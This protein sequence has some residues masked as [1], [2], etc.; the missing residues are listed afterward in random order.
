MQRELH[1]II[2][3]LLAPLAFTMLHA[4]IE[5]EPNNSDAT[6][7]AI[8]LSSPMQGAMGAACSGIADDSDDHFVLNLPFDATLRIT[9][10]S[11]NPTAATHNIDIDVRQD[12][13]LLFTSDRVSGNNGNDSTVT[14]TH[15]CLAKGQY[16]LRLSMAFPTCYQY[17]LLVT[18]VPSLFADDEEPNDDFSAADSQPVLNENVGTEGHVGFTY[19]DDNDDRYRIQ[20]ANDGT[21]SVTLEASRDG[22]IVGHSLLVD[23]YKNGDPIWNMQALAGVNNT[24]QISIGS[25]DCLAAGTY[26]LGVRPYFGCGFSYRLSYGISTPSFANDAEPNNTLAEADA[27]LTLSAN[28]WREGH[29]NFNHAN[30]NGADVSDL[31]RI[32][33]VGD[34]SLTIELEAARAGD[35]GSMLV[36]V[37]RDGTQINSFSAAVGGD[38][39]PAA[40]NATFTCYGSGSYYIAL[41]PSNYCGISYRIRYSLNAPV[42]GNDAESNGT[43][44]MNAT[45]IQP[46]D[47]QAEGHLNFTHYGENDDRWRISL[48]QDGAIAFLAQAEKADPGTGNIGVTLHNNSGSTVG[49]A[50]IAVGGQGL[51][52]SGSLIFPSLPAG[53]YVLRLAASNG[54][55]ISYR[56]DC[57]DT[58]N[59]GQCDGFGQV[60][61]MVE[62]QTTPILEIFPNPVTDVL[63]LRSATKTPAH[64]LVMDA[65]GRSVLSTRTTS[66]HSGMPELNLAE[67][68]AG[69]Y[70][71]H[72]SWADGRASRCF[73]K[74]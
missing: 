5:V 6:A 44:D 47:T 46:H 2:P 52:T 30:A 9:T 12:G 25:T 37:F 72:L 38:G 42:F 14:N 50:N 62:E 35:A 51:P 64:I 23:L 55:G 57:T 54:C 1:R 29:L 34:G 48:T 33:T 7:N 31:F 45:P 69:C 73:V 32:G 43:S 53:H 10:V 13:A 22:D 60:V 70:V 15:T 16:H 68:P 59:D 3:T 28:T 63:H 56:L 66:G 41:Q 39:D 24:G 49:A 18:A 11:N 20:L 36:N 19:G 74:E 40:S 61:G 17:T 26:Y 58:D 21:L 8:T 67:L 65:T 27:Q 71:L 4:Q